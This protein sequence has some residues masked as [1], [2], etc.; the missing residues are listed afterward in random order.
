[1]KKF[2]FF[3][4]LSTVSYGQ[5]AYTRKK[6]DYQNLKVST[7]ECSDAIKSQLNEAYVALNQNKSAK[8][9]EISQKV[10]K[11]NDC[12][13]SHETYA[14]SLFR[15]GEVIKGIEFLETA[16]E[17]FGKNAQLIKRKSLL[18]LELYENGTGQRNI[19]GNSVYKAKSLDYDDDEFKA[20]N[21]NTALNDLLYLVNS[22]EDQHEE[23]YT[24]GKIYQLKKE[25]EKSNIQFQKIV[26]VPEFKDQALFNIAENHLGLKNYPLA[27]EY[28]LKLLESYPNEPQ[29]LSKLSEL[30][31]SSGDKAKGELFNK[32]RYFHK[33]VP[34][35]C[36]M[37]FSEKNLETINYFNDESKDYKSKLNK[38][39]EI[40]KNETQI[41]TIET[42]IAVL[43]IHANHSNGLED[44]A[45]NLL[46][47]IGKP[48]LDKVHKLFN[49]RVSTCT[50]TNLAKVMATTKD[51]SSW[52]VL[53]N[54]LPRIAKMPSTLIPPNVPK[55]IV[56]FNE[57][58]GLREI[59]KIVKPMLS[60]EMPDDAMAQLSFMN[61]HIYFDPLEKISFK[62]I[63]TICKELG[64][65][66]KEIKE[67][68]K[69]L[70]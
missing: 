52:E 70:E 31:E 67:I 41:F 47:K 55:Y 40:E 14:L 58:K 69:R 6:F 34:S 7:E 17:K 48:S 44:D 19:D 27:E 15:S 50:V 63:E 16:I 38:L 29:L 1:M 62:K 9:V 39:K 12:P 20:E 13:E 51:E 68:K 24:I 45:T 3:L 33:L 64:Y 18:L 59:L 56:L 26:D 23:I 28:F 11:S 66:E 10:F 65:N 8:A 46:I 32:K 22:Y 4:F 5:G 35:F 25:F 61:R 42:C 2:L 30:Y 37:E 53:T 49:S 36:E 54:Y 21:L 43:N 57:E 60:E